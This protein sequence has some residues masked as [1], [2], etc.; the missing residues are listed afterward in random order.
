MDESLAFTV[1]KGS[2]D[3]VPFAFNLIKELALYEKAPQEVRVDVA[4]EAWS[5]E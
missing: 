3:D 2:L 1:R 4:L 5:Q